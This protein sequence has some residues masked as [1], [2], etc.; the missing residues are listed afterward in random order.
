MNRRE[1]VKTVGS[2]TGTG[3]LAG[4]TAPN[5]TT[6][7]DML[8][9]GTL[10]V[11]NRHSLPHTIRLTVSD[12]PD[13]AWA[14]QNALRTT[15]YLEPDE[16]KTYSDY[17]SR[18]GRYTIDAQIDGRP[19][20]ENVDFILENTIAQVFVESDGQLNGGSRSI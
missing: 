11:E 1:F 14:V 5:S 15:V 20:K 13:E 8:D 16:K 9:P 17:L 18:E 2:L 12:G 7:T 6:D 10:L 4:C 19:A 3:I